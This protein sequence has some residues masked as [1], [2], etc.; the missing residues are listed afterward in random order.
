MTLND[1]ALGKELVRLEVD[2]KAFIVMNSVKDLKGGM[3]KKRFFK[4]WR[5][6]QES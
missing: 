6:S 5:T 4:E 3:I 2:P 1:Y